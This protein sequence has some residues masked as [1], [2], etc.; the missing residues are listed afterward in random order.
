MTVPGRLPRQPHRILVNPLP[1]IARQAARQL[2]DLLN[3]SCI[4]S[5]AV[6]T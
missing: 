6:H 3:L 1:V 4:L 2:H 5:D